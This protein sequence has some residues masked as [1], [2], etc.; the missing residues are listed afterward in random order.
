[1]PVAQRAVKTVAKTKKITPKKMERIDARIRPDQKERIER[2]AH[3]RGT[4]VSDFIIQN[5]D[6]AAKKTIE[7]HEVWTLRGEAARAFAEAILNPPEPGPR[8]K[9]AFKRFTEE[10]TLR[11]RKAS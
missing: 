1:M 9:A 7:D 3:L 5:A 8:L 2:A 11:E 10:K 6:D 4:S